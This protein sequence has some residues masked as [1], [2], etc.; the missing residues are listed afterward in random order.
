MR[1][2]LVDNLLLELRDGRHRFDLLPHLGLLSLAAVARSG[3]HQPLIYD[4]KLDVAKGL[5]SLNSDLYRRIAELILGQAP[6]VVG[7]TS[8]GCNFICTAKIAA[9]IRRLQPDVPILLGGPHATILDGPILK[10]FSQFDVIVRN[11]G[12]NILLPVLDALATRNFRGISGISY[13]EANQVVSNP[14][15]PL[16]AD[17]DELPWPAYDLWPIRE[18]GLTSTRIE[19]GRGCPF[20]CTF[21]STASFF[22][23]RY[24]LKSAE[25]LCAEMNFLNSSFGIRDFALTHDLFTV[26]RKKV[27]EFCDVVAPFKYTWA[28]SARM[29]CVDRELL[30]RMRAAGCRSIYYGLETGSTRMQKIVEKH[31]DL[32][33]VDATLDTSK[34]LGLF[35]TVS[36]ITGYPQEEQPD[37]DDTLDLVGRCFLREPS[38]LR[39]QLHLLTPEPGTKLMHDFAATLGYDG[40]ITDFNFPTLEADDAAVMESLPDVFMNHHYFPSRIPREQHVFVTSIFAA[41]YEL[42]FPMVRHLMAHWQGSFSRLVSSMYRWREAH[43]SPSHDGTDSIQGILRD[44]YAETHYMT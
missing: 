35:S 10:H 36:L 29:D 17:L 4:P 40:H 2:I 6:D 24:R 25:R 38:E 39:I 31:Q 42:G 23:R 7:L 22:G 5:L 41:L 19:A 13:R 18:L 14:G 27:L 32:S 28:C 12:E 44:Q 33:I 1:L 3:G 26:N 37:Q 20:S 16:I 34:E 21:C 8:L 43:A 9:W 30:T 15:D 11:E